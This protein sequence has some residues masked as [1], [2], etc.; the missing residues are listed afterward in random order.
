MALAESASIWSSEGPKAWP[1]GPAEMSVTTLAEIEMC[2]RRWALNAASYPDL[3]KGRGY[4]PR[5]QLSALAGTVVHLALETITKG[6][7]TAGCPSVQDPAA[8]KLMKDLGGYTQIVNDCIDRV[9]ERLA[10][11]P[12]AKR[13]LEIAVRS[14]RS[15]VPELR[16]RLQTMFSRMQLPL[17]ISSSRADG[18]ATKTRRPLTVGTFS[19]I[20]FRAKEIGWKGK[21]DLLVLSPDVCE[22]SD[23]KTG[24]P[25]DT[26]SFQIQVYALLWNRDA[27]LNPNRRRA[28]R[29]T[30]RY[31]NEETEVAPL[32]EPELDDLETRVVIRTAAARQA[33]SHHPPEA[34]PDPDHCRYCGVRQLCAEYWASQHETVKNGEISQ[35]GDVELSITGRHGPSSWDARVD[36]S[37]HTHRGAT[38]LLRTSGDIEL[39]TGDRIR[40]LDVAITLS[41]ENNTAIV[42]T[43]G[44]LSELYL[45]Q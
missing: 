30:L 25:H 5:V 31:G 29:L 24:A 8:F 35:Y 27:D 6:F 14:L 33:V 44:K 20:E 40:A 32:N 22:I 34:R 38:A 10:S 12:R 36:I 28:N 41:D 7:V 21:A 17:I 39:H 3:W 1:D 26:H 37:R 18:D 15:Q 16:T 42:V 9:L 4:P 11:N 19:E 2:P 45:L 23:F 43:L 13:F